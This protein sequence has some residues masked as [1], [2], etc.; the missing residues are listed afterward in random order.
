M[1][2]PGDGPV[3]RKLPARKR[4]DAGRDAVHV[5]KAG[6]AAWSGCVLQAKPGRPGQSRQGAGKH[7]F[8][9]NVHAGAG[10][11]HPDWFWHRP[12]LC[13]EDP[14]GGPA[15]TMGLKTLTAEVGGNE[16]GHQ[17]TEPRWQGG[18]Q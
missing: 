10:T 11:R 7:S 16:S 15:R 8:P 12:G 17:G 18:K 3:R 9:G 2:G 4:P 13:S 5:A 6:E 14:A 1:R